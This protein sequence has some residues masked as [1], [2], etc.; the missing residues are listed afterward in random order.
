MRETS[1]SEVMQQAICDMGP[2][3]HR[4]MDGRGSAGNLSVVV[5]AELRM[6]SLAGFGVVATG[7]GQVTPA[8]ITEAV[9]QE[10]N[11]AITTLLRHRA[12]QLATG[13]KL[14][15]LSAAPS[16]LKMWYMFAVGFLKYLAHGSFPPR[17][18]EHVMAS[19]A[20]SVLNGGEKIA[21][22]TIGTT[23]TMQTLLLTKM[24]REVVQSA[25]NNEA[26]AVFAPFFL[27]GREFLKI[28]QIECVPLEWGSLEQLLTIWERRHS[29]VCIIREALCMH[30]H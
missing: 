15:S 27:R 20:T 12:T 21:M 23:F 8:V 9:A 24:V 4:D 29:A 7:V 11:Q 13:T 1:Q 17:T 18:E 26:T 25:Q 2:P 14:R 16:A 6:T 28:V 19:V 22:S 30:E 3:S 10:N 5:P